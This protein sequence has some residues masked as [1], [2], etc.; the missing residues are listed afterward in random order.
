MYGFIHIPKTA[1]STVRRVLRREYGSRHC[2]IKVP[3]RK[4]GGHRWADAEDLALARRL[5]PRLAGICGHRVTTFSG[6]QEAEPSLRFFTFLREPTSRFISN[7]Y[8]VRRG[9]PAGS[10]IE[11]LRAFCREPG[12]RNV[13]TRWLAGRDDPDEAIRVLQRDL[14]FVG[15]TESFAES[16]VLF[17]RWWG[18][19]GFSPAYKIVNRRPGPEPLPIRDCPERLALVEEANR[20]DQK[21]Y[22][23]VVDDWFPRCR[24]AY[25]GDLEEDVKQLHH[26]CL[27]LPPYRESLWPKVKRNGLYKPLLH[28][29]G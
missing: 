11:H 9:D 22:A 14:G 29:A 20:A 2:D 13:M 3:K 7:F 21:V 26:A 23:Y 17:A 12:R 24:A 10:T 4:R 25:D 6:L 15:L 5:Y 28:V 18:D 16:M 27:A 1:G 8:H 19:P